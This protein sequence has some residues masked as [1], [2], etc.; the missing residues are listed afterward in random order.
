MNKLTTQITDDLLQKIRDFLDYEADLV[1]VGS[2]PTQA[3]E[4]NW[5]LKLLRELDCQTGGE[6][7]A[8]KG[9]A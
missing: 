6:L 1:A 9:N 3:Y 5:P 2:D 8:R 7:L 4:A